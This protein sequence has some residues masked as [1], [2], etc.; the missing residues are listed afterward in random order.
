MTAVA[1]LRC[2][3]RVNPLGI[4]VMAPRLS[5]RLE[6]DRSG[7]SQRVIPRAG[8]KQRGVAPVGEADLW[9]SGRVESDQ[10]I[11]VVYAG[12]ALESRTT[13]VLAG[14]GVGRGTVNGQASEIAWFEMGLLDKAEWQAKWIGAMLMGGPRTNV[15]APYLRRV[16]EL[17]ATIES[18]RLY[19]TALGLVRMLRS[20]D[21]WWATRSSRRDGRIIASASST[22]YTT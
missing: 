7:A 12:S 9:D 1:D 11:H 4:D 16:F 19:S 15:P 14:D 2:E 8:S 5:W 10:S 20:T 17:P 22:S 21:T 13:R 6:S 3:Y 18:A